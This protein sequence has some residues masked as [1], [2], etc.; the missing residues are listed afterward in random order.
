ME[1]PVNNKITFYTKHGDYIAK[2]SIIFMLGILLS[3]FK[4][5]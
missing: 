3:L 4:K 1:V 5:K 2:I